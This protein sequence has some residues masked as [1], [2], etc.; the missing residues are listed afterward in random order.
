MRAW[1]LW[2]DRLPA[3]VDPTGFATPEDLLQ[4]LTTFSPDDGNGNPVDRFSFINSAQADSQFFG[5]GRYEGY[6]FSYR[7]VDAAG[8]DLRLSRVFFDSPANRA[9]LARGQRILTL[10]GRTI[11]EINAAEGVGAVLVS[12]S[13]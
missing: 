9:G 1:Y 7:A 8:E 3:N 10:N 12:T 2:N 6:G 13:S 4:F 5:E 11:A